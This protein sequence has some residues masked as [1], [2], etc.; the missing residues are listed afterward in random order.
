MRPDYITELLTFSKAHIE[1]IRNQQTY[2][3]IKN[4]I[5]GMKD[6]LKE[7]LIKRSKESIDDAVVN[8]IEEAAAAAAD[9]DDDDDDSAP[10]VKRR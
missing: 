6:K 2:T 1:D 10:S 7:E 4:A 9:D 8:D 3:K 5:D